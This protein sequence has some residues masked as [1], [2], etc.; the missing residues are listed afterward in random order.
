[1]QLLRAGT[2]NPALDLARYISV[3]NE[4]DPGS[5]DKISNQQVDLQ[6]WDLLLFF[7]CVPCRISFVAMPGVTRNGASGAGPGDGEPR[8]DHLAGGRQVS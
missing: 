2:A 6:C 1:M 7:S 4:K 3:L 8:Q 5:M